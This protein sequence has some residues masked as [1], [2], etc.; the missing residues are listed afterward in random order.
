M[1]YDPNSRRQSSSQGSSF[2]NTPSSLQTPAS[3]GVPSSPY[4][5]S[6]GPPTVPQI[7]TTFYE[8]A[9]RPTT[10]STSHSYSRS[11]PAASSEQKYTPFSNT[12]EMSRYTNVSSS[13]QFIPQTPTGAPSQSPLA[14]TD[15][16]P[17]RAELHMGDDPTSPTSAQ[18][19]EPPILQTNSSYIA[20][21]VIYAYDWCNWP[22]TPSAGAGKM[23]VCSYLEDPHNFVSFRFSGKEM[24]RLFLN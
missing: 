19:N 5:T 12:P 18:N 16:R 10:M 8:G 4:D 13:K 6:Q 23:A 17:P 15:I 1:A 3:R 11:S 20:P 14:L 9:A 22:L 24:F 2:S 21:W 7:A